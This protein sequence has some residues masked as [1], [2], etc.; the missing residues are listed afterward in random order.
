MVFLNAIDCAIQALPQADASISCSSWR[1]RSGAGG[2]HKNWLMN[3]RRIR[4]IASR[5]GGSTF[6]SSTLISIST[7][8]LLIEGPSPPSASPVGALAYVE[9]IRSSAMHAGYFSECCWKWF[10]AQRSPRCSRALRHDVVRHRGDLPRAAN[11][12]T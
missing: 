11:N 9:P 2:L 1:H 7:R 6:C 4:S 3:G 12:A 8:T 5:V 10:I